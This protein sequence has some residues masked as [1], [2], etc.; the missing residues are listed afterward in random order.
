L[1]L[2][3]TVTLIDRLRSVDRE[4]KL[5][6]TQQLV[7]V[8]ASAIAGGELKPGAKLPP[9]RDLA[10]IAGINQLTA[11]RCYR[12]LQDQGLVV[13][14][15]GRGTFVRAGAAVGAVSDE[16]DLSWQTYALAPAR[17]GDAGRAIEEAAR[18]AHSPGLI[19]LS[20][21]YP[22]PRRSARHSSM[23]RSRAS[24]TARSRASTSCA[25]SSRRSDANAG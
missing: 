18:H 11:G 7:D 21:G 12:R 1:R 9:T 16:A 20:V 14:A 15:V 22:S 6:L 19:A 17:D 25:P 24:N 2:N 23:K 5:S 13:S 10:E 4:A 8:F 3:D